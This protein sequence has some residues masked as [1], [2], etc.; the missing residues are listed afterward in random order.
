M[1]FYLKKPIIK[2]L[3]YEAVWLMK[4]VKIEGYFPTIGSEIR[5][6]NKDVRVD[7]IL[8]FPYENIKEQ[9]VII[10]L[11]KDITLMEKYGS[12]L[13]Y[14][15]KQAEETLNKLIEEYESNGWIEVD[16]E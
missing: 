9:L 4:E 7:R 13:R 16:E 11:E 12:T 14:Q 6:F 3:F 5:L 8:F 15:G 1:R 10:Y 2:N